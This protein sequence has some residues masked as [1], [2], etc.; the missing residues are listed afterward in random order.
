MEKE[1]ATKRS[2]ILLVTTQGVR[3][4][5]HH[6]NIQGQCKLKVTKGFN[7]P[8]NSITIDAFEGL[9]HTYQPAETAKINIQFANG[10]EWN[11]NFEDLQKALNL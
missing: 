7:E 11:G 10:K 1:T 5:K 6:S 4:G 2:D 3:G 9:G 8:E